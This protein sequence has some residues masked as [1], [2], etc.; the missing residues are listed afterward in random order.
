MQE[1]LTTANHKLEEKD[2]ALAT[3]RDPRRAERDPPDRPDP[4]LTRPRRA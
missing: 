4:A 2:K 3:V 1:A